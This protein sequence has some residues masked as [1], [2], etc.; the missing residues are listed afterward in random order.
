FGVARSLIKVWLRNK[1]GSPE[2]ARDGGYLFPSG[3][4]DVLLP[5]AEGLRADR[6]VTRQRVTGSFAQQQNFEHGVSQELGDS[7]LVVGAAENLR[8]V[9]AHEIPFVAEVDHL[10]AGRLA[11][12]GQVG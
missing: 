7:R 12:G 3:F 9:V 1:P 2:S 11:G 5:R 10:Q 8:Q 6:E 4:C